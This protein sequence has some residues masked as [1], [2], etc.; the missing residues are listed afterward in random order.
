MKK[1][2]FLVLLSLLV[3]HGSNLGANRFLL[4][5][6][7]RTNF[8]GGVSANIFTRYTYDESG[9]RI[10]KRVFDG[11]DSTVAL[12]SR[13]ALS[14]N[15]EGQISQDLL[16]SAS[17]DTLS[18]VQYTYG[19]NGLEI[20][21]TLNKSGSIRFIDRMSYSGEMLTEQSRYNSSGTKIF[22]HR[23]S[24]SRGLLNAD[25]LF[26]SDGAGSFAA[27]Q[28]RL[29]S[30]N[31]DST[32]AQEMQWRKSGTTWYEVSTTKMA[33]TQRLL[34]STAVYEADGS[35]GALTDSISYVYDLNRNRTKESHF[36]KE[37]M[38]TYN[39]V[40]TWIDLQPVGIIISRNAVS[41]AQQRVCY[42]D[43]QI[44]LST[45]FTGT[46]TIY[47]VD[48]CKISQNHLEHGNR[49]MLGSRTANGRYY[50]MFSGI[51]KQFFPITINN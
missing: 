12:M 32:V 16:L 13:E 22:F 48:G 24:Y 30:Y 18:I 3:V 38:L 39:I 6:E 28:T 46:V 49:V 37:R 4:Q 40:Y 45:P 25:S 47:S 41:S 5:T 7:L 26:E 17:G 2:Y 15:I 23:Y 33:Y 36:D 10:F 29:I 1:S 14:Y 11:L 42:R 9:N 27:S 51:S 21:S 50:A 20:V 34:L 19:T 35:S 8:N 44:V 43:G 31:T